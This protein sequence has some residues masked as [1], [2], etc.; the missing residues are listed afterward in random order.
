MISQT[1][2]DLLEIQKEKEM[3]EGNI[4]RMCVADSPIEVYQ[5]YKFATAR[6]L[7]ILKIAERRIERRIENEPNK[8]EISRN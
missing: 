3:L 7:T 4:N 1:R 2:D 8:T 6:L 5:M